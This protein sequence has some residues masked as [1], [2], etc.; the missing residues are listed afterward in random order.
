MSHTKGRTEIVSLARELNEAEQIDGELV[1]VEVLMIAH[2]QLGTHAQA[3]RFHLTLEHL[4]VEHRAS[5]HQ[6]RQRREEAHVVLALQVLEHDGLRLQIATVEH[7][8]GQAERVRDH[9]GCLSA[10]PHLSMVSTGAVFR[11]VRS[12]DG[13]RRTNTDNGPSI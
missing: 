7:T 10:R 4:Q 9:V 5:V 11:R 13:C 3:L 12:T 6:A 1:V 2:R 8:D